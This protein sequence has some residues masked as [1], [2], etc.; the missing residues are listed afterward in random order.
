MAALSKAAQKKVSLYSSQLSSGTPFPQWPHPTA[1]EAQQVCDLLA[2]VHG[3]PE[4]PKELIDRENAPAGC[5]QVPSVL[6][7]LVRTILSQNTTSK[8]STAA[9][10]SLDAV[11][12]RANYRAVL[13]GSPEKLED[14]IR[15]GGLAKNKAKAILGVLKR[16]EERNKAEGREGEDLELGWVREMN[17]E[18]AMKELI[19]FDLVGIKTASCVLLFCLGRDSFA[20]DT[21]V[22]RITQS[23]GWLPSNG[24]V[25]TSSP[26]S[27]SSDD[28]EPTYAR[29]TS[30]T[31]PPTR[32]QTFYHLDALLPP[33]LK[34][35]L[36]SLLVRHGRGCVKCSANG[37]TSQDFVNT[38]PIEHL[39]HKKKGQGSKKGKRKAADMVA[40]GDEEE[41]PVKDDEGHIVGS[42]SACPDKKPVFHTRP[43]VTQEQ[44]ETVGVA[45][46]K[47]VKL[48]DDLGLLPTN[49]TDSPRRSTRSRTVTAKR[50]KYEERSSS[51]EEESEEEKPK[52]KQGKPQRSLSSRAKAT[53]R[54]VAAAG[55]LPKAK[56]RADE[57][58]VDRDEAEMSGRIWVTG[59]MHGMEA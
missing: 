29:R 48:E 41:V 2:S 45:A 49:S 57:S 17:D 23:L 3:M 6:D 20:V 32:D 43:D 15:C 52:P 58:S 10:R 8:N 27:P 25:Y 37:V 4:R 21:H 35:P 7:A 13:Q 42:A 59:E 1:D 53:K 14:A 54:S 55:N 33:H 40:E 36:H 11:Y 46:D 19:S 31:T 22:H 24:S 9:K 47:P 44:I 50:V 16:C 34:Y 5:G 26:T 18:D 38:C 12:G 51:V 56:A 30:T 39:V 28:N